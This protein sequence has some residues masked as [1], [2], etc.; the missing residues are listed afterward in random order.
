MKNK[1]KIIINFGCIFL[2]IYAFCKRLDQLKLKRAEHIYTN[3]CKQMV[4]NVRNENKPSFWIK[5]CFRYAFLDER[6]IESFLFFRL[7]YFDQI[8]IL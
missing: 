6:F 4:S 2:N 1:I 8:N 5:S 7:Q 3:C